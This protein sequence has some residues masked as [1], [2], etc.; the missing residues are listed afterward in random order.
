MTAGNLPDGLANSPI[1]ILTNATTPSINDNTLD[2]R[3]I[4]TR[5]GPKLNQTGFYITLAAMMCEAARGDKEAIIDKIKGRAPG[6]I[7][8]GVIT[9]VP[10]PHSAYDLKSRYALDAL[11]VMFVLQ[12]EQRGQ[13]DSVAADIIFNLPLPDG[14]K[15]GTLK[16]V[17]KRNPASGDSSEVEDVDSIT[18]F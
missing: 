16:F 5:W 18:A 8:D 10:S 17:N 9:R 1:S 7:V 14:T 3:V 2:L 12:V 15:I 11:Y 13:E 6:F 4:P